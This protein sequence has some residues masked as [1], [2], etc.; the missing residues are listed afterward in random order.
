MALSLFKEEP[1]HYSFAGLERDG[2]TVWD[3]VAISTALIHL[4]KVT[5]CDP[6]LCFHTGHE[7]AVVGIMEAVYDPYPD[8]EE[9]NL[10][11]VVVDV[12]PIRRLAKPVTLTQ[13]KDDKAFAD[14]EL[15]KISRLSVMPVPAPIW[16]RIL[17][18]AGE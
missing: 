16:K 9:E 8:P 2:E 12:K 7:K 1:T 15:I 13:L 3:G 18:L 4:R 11:L 10:Q 17:K 5:H 6:V 14:W